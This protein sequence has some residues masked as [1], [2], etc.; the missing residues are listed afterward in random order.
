MYVVCYCVCVCVRVCVLYSSRGLHHMCEGCAVEHSSL[1]TFISISTLLYMYPPSTMPHPRCHLSFTHF[2]HSSCPSVSCSLLPPL[3]PIYHLLSS[4]PPYFS[5][6]LLPYPPSL[7]SSS[8]SSSSLTLPHLFSP[9][10]P[11]PSLP[12]LSSSSLLSP[13]F[14]LPSSSLLLLLL[15][16]PLL[17]SSSPHRPPI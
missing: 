13:P 10:P 9:P 6:F 7:S 14:P 1:W 2:P 4:L 17:L 16:P 5:S 11:S 12:L 3:S 8:L 15:P